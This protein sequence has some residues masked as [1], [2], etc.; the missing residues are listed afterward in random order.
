MPDFNECFTS[1]EIADR[2]GV[3][4]ST[5]RL[6]I[7]RLGIDHRFPRNRVVFAEDLGKLTIAFQ[8]LGYTIPDPMQPAAAETVETAVEEGAPCA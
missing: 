6:V 5:V 4:I 8:T 7:E 1:R 3:P 2:F